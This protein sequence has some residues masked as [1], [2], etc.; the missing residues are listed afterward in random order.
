MEGD[1][2]GPQSYDDLR[3]NRPAVRVSAYPSA[4]EPRFEDR[5]KGPLPSA[6]KAYHSR[7][8]HFTVSNPA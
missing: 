6:W 5:L 1:G 7:D 4:T 8:Q 3:V 2:I